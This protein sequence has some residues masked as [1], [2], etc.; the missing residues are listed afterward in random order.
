MD[1][2]PVASNKS[3]FAITR[4]DE[5]KPENV[6]LTQGYLAT[7]Y[8]SDT[9]QMVSGIAGTVATVMQEVKRGPNK[10]KSMKRD[11]YTGDVKK[12][13]AMLR[14]AAREL[15]IG[16]SIRVIPETFASGA[17]KGEPNGKCTVHFLGKDAKRR[18]EVPSETA[19]LES[20]IPLDDDDDDDDAE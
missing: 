1:I 18:R 7:S 14:E 10:G 9:P 4:G 17:K 16:V 6:F 11:E 12:V 13:V 5:P 8:E 19:G 2:K 3:V 20:A 15:E